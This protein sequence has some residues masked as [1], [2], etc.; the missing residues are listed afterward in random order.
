ME[1]FSG[2]LGQVLERSS[3]HGPALFLYIKLIN[4]YIAETDVSA[5]SFGI[6]ID[7]FC[8]VIKN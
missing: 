6:K 4:N 1:R 2:K 3:I 5:V 7:Y 8:L